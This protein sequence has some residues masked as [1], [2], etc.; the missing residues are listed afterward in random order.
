MTLLSMRVYVFTCNAAGCEDV[1]GDIV[2]PNPDDGARSAW[3]VASAVGWTCAERGRH[4]CP[5]HGCEG[6]DVSG[7]QE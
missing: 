5:A 7:A 4:Y 6:H 2:P 1:T 3:R